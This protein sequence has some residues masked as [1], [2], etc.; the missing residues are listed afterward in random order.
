[1]YTIN[2]QQ[3]E[4]IKIYLFLFALMFLIINWSSVS[5]VFNYREMYGLIHGFFNPYEES[6][7][8]ANAAGIDISNATTPGRVILSTAY[9]YSS[10]SNS[11]EIPTIGLVTPLVIG[12][13]TNISALEKDLDK[14]VVYYPGSVLPG[15][16]GQI[17]I[18]GHSAPP[19]WPHIKHDWVF[20]DIEDLNVGEQ[21]ILYFNNTQY[22]YRIIDKKV[23]Q[24]GEEIR[25]NGLDATNN[26]LTIVSC[27]PPGKDYKRMTVQ[28]E[29]I[30]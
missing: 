5:W 16:K 7:L 13:S 12:S 22:T 10:K 30:R 9:P 28:A 26:I 15:E 1:M 14:G 18:L 20:T 6:P 25:A 2:K 3:K 11:L 8:L 24:K 21:I 19:N 27:W 17:I 23:I 29:L 4:L